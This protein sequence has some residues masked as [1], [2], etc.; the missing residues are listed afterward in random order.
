MGA[1]P[2]NRWIQTE[3]LNKL[4][5]LVL[6]RQVLDKEEVEVKLNRVGNGLEVVP[7]HE[8]DDLMDVD[9]DD[10]EDDN[11]EDIIDLD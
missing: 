11:D 5:V 3:I 8:T 4:A 6:K 2:L 7:N 10:W 1:R 9:V